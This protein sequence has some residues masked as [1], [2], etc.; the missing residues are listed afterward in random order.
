MRYRLFYF[1]LEDRMTVLSILAVIVLLAFLVESLVEYLFGTLAD[2]IA[3]IKPYS[4]LTMYVAAAVGV[5]GAFVYQFDLLAL[6]GSFL[7]TP[8]ALSTFG[9]ILTGLAIGR[10]ANYLHDLIKR[11][12]VKE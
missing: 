7:G 10:G 9:I 3:A 8:I 2:H 1:N 11:Y 12:F 6:L 4:W 5:L